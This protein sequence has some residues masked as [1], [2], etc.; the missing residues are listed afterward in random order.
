MRTSASDI[1][2][3]VCGKGKLV[4][5]LIEHDVGGL[6]GMKK[7]VVSE[8]PALVCSTCGSVSMYGGVLE[9]ISL[10]LAVTILSSSELDP[11]EVR[12]LRK[13][14]GDT[15]D[16][17]ARRL[18][19]ARITVNRWEQ[20]DESLKGPDAYAIRSHTFFRLRGSSPVIE[21]AAPAFVANT[22]R[23]RKRAQGYKIAGASLHHA[24]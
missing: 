22:P 13:L 15:Q 2:C 19:V 21:A 10:L 7:V 20:G 17:F 8:L 9:Q 16:E 6:L 18:G 23:T 11:L 1:R 4:H 14:I 5:R 3:S 12:Y 24:H